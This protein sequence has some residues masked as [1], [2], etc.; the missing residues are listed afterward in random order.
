MSAY[1]EVD[2]AL[3]PEI[4]FSFVELY[5]KQN[6]GSSAQKQLNKGFKYFCEGYI[7]NLRGK[8]LYRFVL[9]FCCNAKNYI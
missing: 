8:Q 1:S 9:S 5:I 2:L 7:H 6:K 4:S 3:V